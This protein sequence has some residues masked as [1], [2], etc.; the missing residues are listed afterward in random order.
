MIGAT[1]L[2]LLEIAIISITPES[3]WLPSIRRT[4]LL[5]TSELL[6]L[7]ARSSEAAPQVA[8]GLPSPLESTAP[9]GRPRSLSTARAFGWVVRSVGGRQIGQPASV[10]LGTA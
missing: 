7:V 4:P 1:T 8:L 9:H 6:G 3:S 2:G 10:R 5:W